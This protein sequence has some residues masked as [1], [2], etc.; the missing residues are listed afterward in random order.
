[1]YRSKKVAL[2]AYNFPHLK[3]QSFLLRMMI[4]GI[5]PDVILAADPV[6]LNVP[7]SSIK[8][9]IRH[10]AV[11]NT[12]DLAYF[13]KIPFY[14]VKHNSDFCKGI[15]NEMHIDVAVISGARILKKKVIEA[16]PNGIINFHP[17]LIPEARG[18]DAMLWSI[19]NDVPLGITS[20]IIDEDIDAGKIL[21]INKINIYKQDTIFDLSERLVEEQTNMLVSAFDL[22]IEEKYLPIPLVNTNYNK[23]MPD[24]LEIITLNKLNKY[25][26]NFATK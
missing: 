25:I 17:G 2:I 10:Q 21:E 19:Y 4:E 7:P 15:L 9:K 11:I 24:E 3:T 26:L 22:A 23:K 5:I 12:I 6:T 14:V 13:F 8:T 1:M 20:H 18:L 16:I